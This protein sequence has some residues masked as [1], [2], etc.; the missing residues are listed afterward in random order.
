MEK[1]G[2]EE[3]REGGRGEE[4]MK[5]EEDEGWNGGIRK[6]G[7]EG[8][9]NPSRIHVYT[10]Q[11]TGHP[12]TLF[13]LPPPPP[14]SPPNHPSLTCSGRRSVGGGISIGKLCSSRNE[15]VSGRARFCRASISPLPP[16][17]G[18]CDAADDDVIV[19]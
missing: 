3:G 13:L 9:E 4:W 18:S 1:G 6:E 15:A 19:D 17:D 16:P 7:R 5:C 10:C 14:P 2:K 12:P 8:I 11:A